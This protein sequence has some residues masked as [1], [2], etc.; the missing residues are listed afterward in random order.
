MGVDLTYPGFGQELAQLWANDAG[1][2]QH[3]QQWLIDAL[4]GNVATESVI[5]VSFDGS[6]CTTKFSFLNARLEILAR[7]Q[8]GVCAFTT[9]V[10]P[11]NL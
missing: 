6:Y 3:F 11:K 5:E 10:T 2:V 1:L 4:P 9:I 7:C 8:D